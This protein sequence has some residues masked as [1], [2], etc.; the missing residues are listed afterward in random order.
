MKAT[1]RESQDIE[2]TILKFPMTIHG[3][4]GDVKG[5]KGDYL[6]TEGDKQYFLSPGDFIAAFTPRID[7]PSAPPT[8]VPYPVPQP[9]PVWT[10]PPSIT[11]YYPNRWYYTTTITSPNVS[12]GT[13]TLGDLSTTATQ[14]GTVVNSGQYVINALV[15]G[16][17]ALESGTVGE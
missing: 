11:P 5:K 13:A 7:P 3:P 16:G 1:R 6:I 14:Q 4:N 12:I 8:Y 2:Y 9:Y 10:P 15:S 17:L